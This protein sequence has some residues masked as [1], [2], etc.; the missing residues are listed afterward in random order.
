MD[1]KKMTGSG[2][3]V[4]EDGTQWLS[5]PEERF[6]F[7]ASWKINRFLH[8]ERSDFQDVAVV[9]TEGFGKTLVL[10]EI[11]QTT[12]TDGFIYNEMITHIPLATHPSPAKSASS[13]EG[14]AGPPGKR[15]S[16]LR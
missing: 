5:D 2:F 1:D 15:S 4:A 7:R 11:V 16:T 10:D 13:G 3:F 12:E 14:T 6:G 8:R 9:E